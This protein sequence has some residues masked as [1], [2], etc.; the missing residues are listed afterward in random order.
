MDEKR[1]PKHV[2]HEYLTQTNSKKGK[3][4]HSKATTN[5][6]MSLPCVIEGEPNSANQV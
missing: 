5:I 1:E 3:M 4:K 6:T 2:W